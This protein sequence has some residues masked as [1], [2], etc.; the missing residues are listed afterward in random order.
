MA[1][2][3]RSVR[4]ERAADGS[5]FHRYH[6][7]MQAVHDANA[8]RLAAIMDEHG[9]PGEPQRGRRRSGRR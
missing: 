4:A 3:D 5:L 1:A 6:P 9:W 2:R 7:R 8:V